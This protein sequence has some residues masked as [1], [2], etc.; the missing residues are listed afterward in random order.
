MLKWRLLALL[1]VVGLVVTGWQTG[2][3]DNLDKP[4]ALADAL[5]AMGP[6]GY[7]AFVV[8]YAL[9]QP[10]GIPGTV[11]VIAAPLIWPWPVAFALNMTGTMLASVIGFSFARFVA[12]D[13]VSARIPAC[14]HTY[15]ASF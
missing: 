1:L 13:W 14:L 12:R 15:D 5:L 8:T 2:L 9:L 10:F 11:F 4:R 7:L 6:R 3:F